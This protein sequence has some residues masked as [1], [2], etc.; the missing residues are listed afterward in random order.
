MPR[1]KQIILNWCGATPTIDGNSTVLAIGD[2]TQ[3]LRDS[4]ITE[5]VNA[6]D[7]ICIVIMNEEYMSSKRSICEFLYFYIYTQIC[8]LLISE[9][10]PQNVIHRTPENDFG[11]CQKLPAVSKYIAAAPLTSA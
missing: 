5:S 2:V 7:I 8:V 4:L 6:I 10:E 11:I 1:Y 9:A 3:F